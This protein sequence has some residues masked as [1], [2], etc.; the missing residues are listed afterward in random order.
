MAGQIIRPKIKQAIVTL[1]N[2]S[3]AKCLLNVYGYTYRLGVLPT[4]VIETSCCSEKQRIK[5]CMNRERAE[6]NRLSVQS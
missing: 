4:S 5:R 6:N 3:V 1:L 2:E